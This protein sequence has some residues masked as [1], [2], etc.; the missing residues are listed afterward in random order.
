MVRLLL[1]LESDNALFALLLSVMV[2]LPITWNYRHESLT[3][4]VEFADVVVRLV[5]PP[6]VLVVIESMV[7][8]FLRVS[9]LRGRVII[10]GMLVP[11]NLNAI[12]RDV[13]ILSS[14]ILHVLFP[15]LET[16][17]LMAVLDLVLEIA[18]CLRQ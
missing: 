16:L 3:L 12:I 1:R 17:R 14:A 11:V 10:C 5:M 9:I 4:V 2:P 7:E 15:Q 18:M 13:P 6:F 8:L